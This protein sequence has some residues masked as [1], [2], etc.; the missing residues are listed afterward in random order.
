MMQDLLVNVGFSLVAAIVSIVCVFII[1]RR[2][3]RYDII[4]I[5]WGLVFISIATVVYF[6]QSFEILSIQTLLL[7]LI[8]V[9]GIRLSIHIYARWEKSKKEDSRYADLRMSY[10][11]KPGGEALNMFGR[12]YAVQALLAAV[13]ML[14]FIVVVSTD[15]QFAGWAVAV[16]V[17]MWLIGFLF[18]TIGDWQLANHIQKA[19]GKRKLMTSGL[20][21]Y[22]RH[23]NYFGEVVQW[24]G[25]FIVTITAPLWYIAILGPIT[26]TLL[27][28]FVSGVSLS[29]KRFEGRTGWAEYKHRTSKF[30]PLPP[31]KG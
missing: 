14:P 13:V 6:G 31:K 16:G 24:W 26:I 2:I 5:A 22:T 7:A 11:P 19:A 3:G 4:D 9:W 30:L 23:P 27:I 20:W 10:K 25:I 12:V 17:A 28:L 21:K 15:V 1:A 18:E 8:F 29:E